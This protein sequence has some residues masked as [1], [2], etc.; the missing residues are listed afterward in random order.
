MPETKKFWGKEGES[1]K[2]GSQDKLDRMD[3]YLEWLLTPKD[4][5]EPPSKAKL[6]ESLGIT[7]QTLRNYDKDP[8]FQRR[9]MEDARTAAKVH[10][11]PDLLEALYRIA[12]GENADGKRKTNRFGEEVFPSPGASVS[13]AKVLIDHATALAPTSDVEA[14]DVKSMDQEQLANLA[15]ALLNKLND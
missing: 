8:H 14:V 5:R 13:A 12:Q 9:L 1:W 6:A 3:E 7:Q 4:Y 2:T 10:K 11:L 15:I